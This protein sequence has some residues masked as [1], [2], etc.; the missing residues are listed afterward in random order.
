VAGTGLPALP[1]L[2]A[3]ASTSTSPGCAKPLLAKPRPAAAVRASS[4]TTFAAAAGVNGRRTTALSTMAADHELW[5]DRCGQALYLDSA[6]PTAQASGTSGATTS[7]AMPAATDVLALSSRPGSAR[8]LYLD[9][10]GATITGTAWNDDVG[11]SSFDAKPYSEDATVDTTF[12]ADEQQQIYDT[13]RIVSEDYAPFDVNVTTQDPGADAITRTDS[14]DTAYGTRVVI[15]EGGPV[16]SS[17][18]LCNSGCGGIAYLDAFSAQDSD[19][20]KPA[21]VFTDGASPYGVYMAQAAS[22]E[23]GHNFGLSHDGTPTAGYSEGA[24][25]WAPIMGAS[26]YHPLSQWSQGEYT[27]ANNT[28]D[29][30]AIIAS[31]APFVAD[32]HGDTAATATP[33]SADQPVDGLI[34]TRS[35]VDAFTFTATGTTHLSVTPDQEQSDL[36]VDLRIVDATGNPVAHVDPQADPAATYGTDPTPAWLGATWEVDLPAGTSA[37]YTA[38]VDGTGSGDPTTDGDYSDYGSMGRYRISLATGATGAT[39]PPPLRV[40]T[41]SLPNGKVAATY[42]ARITLRGATTGCTWRVT[43]TPPPGLRL[44]VAA[45]RTRATWVGTPTRRGVF[46]FRVKVRDAAG[47]RA[48]RDYT[49]RIVRR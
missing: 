43:G 38:F 29:D 34:S 7:Q 6:Q 17:P 47:H 28:E 42:S 23:A 1:D 49:V 41:L 3:S 15:T 32:D 4:A 27:G 22:H 19:Y 48:H 33:V 11:L 26:Y 2:P 31:Q 35:D 8:T 39:P 13:W 40:A 45:N 20:T 30:V 10:T 37:T 44:K 14:A 5:L 21:F 16:Y 24:G 12:S 25:N 18:S 9:F 46:G 36:D